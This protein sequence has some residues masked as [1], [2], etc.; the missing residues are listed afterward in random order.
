MDEVPRRIFE[1]SNLDGQTDITDFLLSREWLVTNGLGGY[2]S[3]TIGNVNTWRYHGI[4]ISAEAEPLGRI[5]VVK[6]LSEQIRFLHDRIVPIT[7]EETEPGVINVQGAG[8]LREFRLEYG[9]PVWRYKVED[10]DIER[11]IF[12]LHR[13]NTVY[14]NYR[15][16]SAPKAVQ[17]ELRPFVSFRP[18][19][20]SDYNQDLPFTLHMQNGRYEVSAGEKLPSLRMSLRYER[21]HFV[22]EGGMNHGTFFRKDAERGYEAQHVSWTPGFFQIPITP[23]QEITLILSTENWANIEA[24]KPSEALDFEHQRRSGLIEHAEPSVQS[25]IAAELIL[26]ADQFLFE[27]RGRLRDKV[28]AY[29]LDDKVRAVIAG[30]HWFTDWGR[31]TMIALEGLTLT[32]GRYSDARGIL[33]TFNRYVRDGLIPNFIPEG[34]DE[35]VYH[36]A[37]ATLWYFHALDRYLVYTDDRVTLRF[38]LPSLIN[39]IEHHINGTRF[40]IHVDTSDGLL[41]QGKEGYQ[42]TWMDAKV[43]GWVVTPRRGKP[44]EINGLFYN[45]LC[46]LAEWLE[47]EG[48]TGMAIKYN[49]HAAKLRESFNERFWFEDGNYLYDVIDG[50]NGD[51][52]ACRPNQLISFSL[53]Y[54]VLDKKYWKPVIEIVQQ[55]LLTPIGLRSLSPDHPDYKPK[56]FGDLRARDAAYHQ[57]T[58]WPWLIGPFINAYLALNPDSRESARKFLGGFIPHINEACIGSISEICDA[59]EPFIPR[60]CISQAWSVAEVLRCWAKTSEPSKQ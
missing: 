59:E 18:Q 6:N 15:I 55:E 35:G 26:A 3:G 42:L 34:A 46:L 14:V 60:G 49:E 50:E 41:T 20:Q 2:A 23:G 32:T 21:I 56:Y 43:D 37:D 9:I 28:Q 48:E 24:M 12:M 10:V 1:F 4:L 40:G 39:I 5:M 58:V 19:Q 36:T 30:Y 7:G 47:T 29:A 17:L 54:P 27:P 38:L 16:L 13:Q 25:G 57:G 11:T 53:K 8:Q 22:T 31:D 52:S 33:R 51:D 45:A 44:V